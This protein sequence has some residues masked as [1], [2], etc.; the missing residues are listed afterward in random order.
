MR[1]TFKEKGFVPWEA[2]SAFQKLIS[3]VNEDKNQ[4]DRVGF[5]EKEPFY[6]NLL[7][8]GSVQKSLCKQCGS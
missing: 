7:P 5:P 2:N 1:S 3:N 6:L 8:V 4:I